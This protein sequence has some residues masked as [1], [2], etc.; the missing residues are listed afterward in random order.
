MLVAGL[1]LLW[2]AAY[3]VA[4]VFDAARRREAAFDQRV[5]SLT[6]ARLTQMEPADDARRR[7]RDRG[8]A[9]K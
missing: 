5:A 3:A 9:G 8:P 4:S 7:A 1:A 6:P 2:F